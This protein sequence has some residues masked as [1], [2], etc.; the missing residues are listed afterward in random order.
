MN[1]SSTGNF[2]GNVSSNGVVIA[3]GFTGNAVFVTNTEVQV[4]NSTQNSIITSTRVT[5]GNNSVNTF[6][7]SAESRLGGNTV[8]DVINYTRTN[9]GTVNG[10][11]T[12]TP[13]NDIYQRAQLNGATTVQ[14]GAFP[15]ANT[16]GMIFVEARNWGNVVVT[17]ANT[18]NWAQGNGSYTTSFANSGT[19]LANSGTNWITVWSTDGGVTL[20]GTAI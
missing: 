4:G 13:G 5:V 1:V 14:F 11:I 3:R 20:Y 9:L 15:A 8:V 2:A 7:S 19:A 17:F 18:V 16:L 6:L 12:F 10:T